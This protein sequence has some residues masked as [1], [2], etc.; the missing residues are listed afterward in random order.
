MGEPIAAVRHGTR[1][2]LGTEWP[3]ESIVY[4]YLDRGRARWVLVERQCNGVSRRSEIFRFKWTALTALAE[5][6]KADGTE[7]LV[8]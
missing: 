6:A 3:V 1:L 8:Y 5:I 4:R 2:I 7:M